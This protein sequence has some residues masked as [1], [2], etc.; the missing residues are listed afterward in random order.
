L[1]TAWLVVCGWWC[2]VGNKE[3]VSL[4]QESA[5]ASA[6]TVFDHFGYPSGTPKNVGDDACNWRTRSLSLT[7]ILCFARRCG[8]R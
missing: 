8:R 5:P 6:G 2:G 4:R 7:T 3:M 1:G